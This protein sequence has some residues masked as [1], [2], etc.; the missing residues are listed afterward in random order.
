MTNNPPPIMLTALYD[1][2]LEPVKLGK[3]LASGSEGTVYTARTH[4]G[5]VAKL[6]HQQPLAESLASKLEYMV[7]NPPPIVS[8]SAYRLAWPISVVTKPKRAGR[9]VGYLMSQIDPDHYREI[10]VYLNPARRKRR[11]QRR[12]KPYTFLHLLVMAQNLSHA[13][14]HIHAQGHVIGDL[15]SRNVLANDRGQVAL[16]DT[17]SFQ[18]V[19]ATTGQ[20]HRCGVGTPEYTA[21]GLQGLPFTELDRSQN[22]DRFALSVMIYQLLFQG[23][24]PFAGRYWQPP[25]TEINTLADRIRMASFAHGPQTKIKHQPSHPA[26][27]IWQDSPMK[28]QFQAAFRRRGERTT[29]EDWIKSIAEAGNVLSQCSPNPLHHY[30]STR[31]CTWCT[32]RTTTGV[33]PFDDIVKPE[34]SEARSRRAPRR[35]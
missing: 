5:T 7:A 30:F 31:R 29:A 17:D 24:H 23:Q 20:L 34:Q 25:D 19:D 4:P 21:P 32:Y 28:K 2:R 1:Q 11:A 13:V 3:A 35:A 14:A 8:C 6:P 9:T 33:E 22:D 26:A 15:N 27:V 12:G 18:V 10:G 16:I